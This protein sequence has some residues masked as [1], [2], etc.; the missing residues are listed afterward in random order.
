L[1][2]ICSPIPVRVVLQES[3][4]G[5][6]NVMNGVYRGRGDGRLQAVGQVAG[7]SSKDRKGGRFG[8]E[9]TAIDRADT[10]CG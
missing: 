1:V 10:T 5:E 8:L 7:V 9:D 4:V 6:D 3:S 2:Y